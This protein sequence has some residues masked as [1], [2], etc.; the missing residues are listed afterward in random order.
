MQLLTTNST[1]TEK[2]F[3]SGNL[4]KEDIN[5]ST[6]KHP[7]IMFY[8]T[9]DYGA[10]HCQFEGN[11]DQ[12]LAYRSFKSYWYYTYKIQTVLLGYILWKKKFKVRE[13]NSVADSH[14]DL[15]HGNTTDLSFIFFIY[16]HVAVNSEINIEL[17]VLYF[18]LSY[19]YFCL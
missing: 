7:S 19:K 3:I 14:D 8:R 6:A 18:A 15:D 2:Y 11:T 13:S 9:S 5:I 17:F 16:M 10:K 4:L 1:T 12:S